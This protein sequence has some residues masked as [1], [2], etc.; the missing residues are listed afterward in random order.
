M[1]VTF[2]E[3]G[4]LLGSTVIS[5]IGANRTAAASITLPLANGNHLI[6]VVVDPNDAIQ[7]ISKTNNQATTI[8]LVGVTTPPTQGGLLVT[9][10]IPSTVYSSS[11]FTVSGQA[12]Y[13]IYS[14]GVEYTNYVVM[15]GSV[16]ITM[17][18]SDGTT[19]T[20]GN[21]HTDI[22]GNFPNPSGSVHPWHLSDRHDR[23]R[24]HV[25]R[26]AATGL[27][28]DRGSFADDASSIHDRPV[29]LGRIG[30]LPVW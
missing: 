8:V 17:T 11:L 16:Q 3:F 4:N 28:G 1:T 21:A 20:Y 6:Q 15:G 27:R 18:A 22:D 29:C 30:L 25:H 26:H 7:E 5:Q 9:G 2:S 14:N 24:L 10:S 12:V 13:D 19:W 23:D